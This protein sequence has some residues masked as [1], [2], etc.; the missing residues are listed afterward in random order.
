MRKEV[1]WKT[2]HQVG[3]AGWETGGQGQEKRDRK[4]G[5]IKDGEETGDGGGG[6]SGTEARK[7]GGDEVRVG[8]QSGRQI[9]ERGEA[10]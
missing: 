10:I 7:W 9:R 8:G 5:G 6:G 3:R 1:G 4:I 2:E